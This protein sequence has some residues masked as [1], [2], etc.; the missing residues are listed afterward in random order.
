MNDL[1]DLFKKNKGKKLLAIFPHPDDESFV[2][3]GLFQT[4]KEFGLKTSLICLTRGER[5]MNGLKTENLKQLRT[6]EFKRAVEILGLD[7]FLL[8]NYADA[9]LRKTKSKWIPKVKEVLQKKKP[10]IVLT[11]DHSGITGHPDHIVSCHEILKLV[12]KMKTNP[13]LLWR[14]PDEQE[15]KYFKKN[16]AMPYASNP[17][18]KLDYGLEESVRKIKAVF[19]HKSQMQGF[20]F[21]LQILEWFLFDHKE[22][23]HKVDLRREYKYRFVQFKV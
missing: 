7:K 2:A 5:G 23:Y 12:K 4:A 9:D 18:F 16:K 1:R 3:G 6:K 21:K 19:A 20:G 22:F 17:N 14:V 11:F 8:W 10:E 15:K 13:A